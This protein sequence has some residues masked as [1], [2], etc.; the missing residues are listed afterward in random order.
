MAFPTNIGTTAQYGANGPVITGAEVLSWDLGDAQVK[1]E[2][3][4]DGAGKDIGGM[5]YQ[6]KAKIDFAML[7]LTLTAGAFQALF[8]E[9]L[10]CTLTGYTNYR[11]RS[12]KL[13]RNKGPLRVT[14]SMVAEF[15]TT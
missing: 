15:A 9:H 11:V 13:P 3:Y 1:E 7:C 14:G 2:L 5:I 12:A 8:P 6:I 4:E 10:M